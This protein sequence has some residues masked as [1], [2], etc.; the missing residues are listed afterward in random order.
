MIEIPGLSGEVG[1]LAKSAGLVGDD[2]GFNAAWF[3]DPLGSLRTI[4]SN[5]PQRRPEAESRSARSAKG[6]SAPGGGTR[7]A[8]L[9]R[10]P[11]LAGGR[12]VSIVRWDGVVFGDWLTT[13]SKVTPSPARR[14]SIEGLVGSGQP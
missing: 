8:L 13:F 12:P 2:G 3:N 5:A 4:L 9:L 11:W 10:T 1:D 6:R 14:R 7:D